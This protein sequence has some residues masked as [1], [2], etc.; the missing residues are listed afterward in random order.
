SSSA[1]PRCELS[2]EYIDLV[3]VQHEGGGHEGQ[4]PNGHRSQDLCGLPA[5]RGGPGPSPDG[6]GRRPG[7]RRGDP[8]GQERPGQPRDDPPPIESTQPAPDQAEQGDR[9]E[10]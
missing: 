10:G 8:R 4:D 3:N 5:E 7:D 9:A 6:P 2:P 1:P